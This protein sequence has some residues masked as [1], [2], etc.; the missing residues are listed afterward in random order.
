MK[1]FIITLTSIFCF[2][3]ILAQNKPNSSKKYDIPQMVFV[4][5]GSFLMGCDTAYKDERPIHKVTLSDFFIGKYE[6]TVKQ[7]REFCQATG[8][9]FPSLPDPEWYQEHPNTP[10]WQWHD[11]NPIVN[12]N[13]Y[14]AMAYCK[15]LSKITG[16]HY[17]LPTEAQWEYAARGGRYS[18]NYEFSGSNNIN[19]VAWYDETTY[20]RG[21][22]P[23]GLLKPNELGIYDMSG[24]AFEWCLDGYGPYPNHPV[25]DPLL[26]ENSQYRVVRGGCWYYYD[27]YCRV[28]ERDGP[29]ANLRTFYYG[30]RVV[31]IPTKKE[32]KEYYKKHHLKRHHKI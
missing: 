13:W 5:G 26:H 10:K 24:N 9:K 28:T 25:K 11:N 7:Y 18:H 1:Y 27:E 3:L 16:E 20:E 29:K 31:K 15:W 22:R 21:T 4:Q 17:T 19:E 32:L 14:D 12:V 23:V 8:H 6:V 30:F 2:N